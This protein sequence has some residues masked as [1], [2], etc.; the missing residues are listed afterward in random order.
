[1]MLICD[2]D[3]L[4]FLHVMINCDS[5]KCVAPGESEPLTTEMRLVAIGR[6][7]REAKSQPHAGK[8]RDLAR[9]VSVVLVH[10]HAVLVSDSLKE[11]GVIPATLQADQL[12]RHRSSSRCIITK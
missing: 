2:P 11:V 1:M 10:S 8:L 7:V 4:N 6:H 12:N 5:L 3:S 9:I